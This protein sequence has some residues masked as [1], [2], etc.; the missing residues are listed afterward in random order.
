MSELAQVVTDES[1]LFGTSGWCGTVDGCPALI[2][3]F[4]GGA[5][6]VQFVDGEWRKELFGGINEICERLGLSD[7]EYGSGKL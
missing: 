4:Y 6:L 7:E 5:Y 1:G 3:S 2:L